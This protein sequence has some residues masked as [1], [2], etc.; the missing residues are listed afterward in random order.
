MNVIAWLEFELASYDSAALY[1]FVALSSKV[2]VNKSE[3]ILVKS[4]YF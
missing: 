1:I 2:V 3:K 4:F